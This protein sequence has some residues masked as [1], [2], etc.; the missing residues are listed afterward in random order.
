MPSERPEKMKINGRK[1]P[2]SQPKILPSDHDPEA[3]SVLGRENKRQIS[4]NIKE[5][6]K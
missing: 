5:T 3:D 2:A 1:M 4:K 6:D